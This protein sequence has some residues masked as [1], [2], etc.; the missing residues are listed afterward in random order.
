M[1]VSGC[2]LGT[3]VPFILKCW[4]IQ[5]HLLRGTH[6]DMGLVLEDLRFP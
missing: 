1:N 4:L 3:V 2:I 5:M 6:R